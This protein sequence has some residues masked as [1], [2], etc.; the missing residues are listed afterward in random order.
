MSLNS[1]PASSAGAGAMAGSGQAGRGGAKDGAGTPAHA[2]AS[3]VLEV[4]PSVMDSLRGAMRVQAGEQ[5][6]IPQFRCLNFIART[7]GC[8]VGAAAAFLGVTMPTASAM[9]DR[10]VRAGSVATCADAQDRRRARLTLT[11]AGRT[12]LR[13]MRRGARVEVARVLSACT[14]DELRIVQEALA[15]LN[16]VFQSEPNRA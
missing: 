2:C 6:S 15:V 1:K 12:Q 3:A 4:V 9:V 7:P 14:S 13:A 10:L 8:S 11:D 5:M 16:R